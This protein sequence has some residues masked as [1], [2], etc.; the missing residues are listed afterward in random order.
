[1][2]GSPIYSRQWSGRSDGCD[3]GWYTPGITYAWTLEPAGDPNV[4]IDS[5]TIEDPTLTINATGVWDAT[6]TVEDGF[7]T[8]SATAQ[9]AVSANPCE[10][11][12]AAGIADPVG[13]ITGDCAANIADLEALALDWM[14]D[15]RLTEN[16]YF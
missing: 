1:M 10:A 12:R 15:T 2:A 6:L 8:E 7:W 5:T 16:L 14:D 3:C 11:A 9:V 4:A 13:D